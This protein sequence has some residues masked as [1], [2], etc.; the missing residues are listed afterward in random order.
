[1]LFQLHHMVEQVVACFCRSRPGRRLEHCGAHFSIGLIAATSRGTTGRSRA[2]VDRSIGEAWDR[3]EALASSSLQCKRHVHDTHVCS[4][5][6]SLFTPRRTRASGA[7][8]S[9]RSPSHRRCGSTMSVRLWPDPVLLPPHTHTC[10][11]RINKQ[12][13]ESSKKEQGDDAGRQ[14]R[15]PLFRGKCEPACRKT[16]A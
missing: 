12:E 10:L 16:E 7:A 9:H 5:P 13:D 11:N 2:A 6:H 1:M 14:A 4:M 8:Q 3:L 15:A